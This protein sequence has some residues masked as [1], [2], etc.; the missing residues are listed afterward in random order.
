MGTRTLPLTLTLTLVLVDALL[1]N[2][3]ATTRNDI[4]I[5]M[6]TSLPFDYN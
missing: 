6:T 1:H 4:T 3:P 2:L 5:L